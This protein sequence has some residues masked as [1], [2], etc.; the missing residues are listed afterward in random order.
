MTSPNLATIFGPNLLHR[1]NVSDK[2]YSMQ[3]VEVEE[4]SAVIGVVQKMI[5]NYKNLF[6]VSIT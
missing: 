3:A 1:E 4:S 2:D 5:D 6:I